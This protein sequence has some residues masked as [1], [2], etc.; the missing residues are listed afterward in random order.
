MRMERQTDVAKLIFAFRNFAKAHKSVIL[1]RHV[2]TQRKML[3]GKRLTKSL[4]H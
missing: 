4:T 1:Y 3:K 2:A